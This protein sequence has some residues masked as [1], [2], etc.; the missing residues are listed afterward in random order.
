M[1]KTGPIGFKMSIQRHL[2]KDGSDFVYCTT[3]NTNLNHVLSFCPAATPVGGSRWTGR[4]KHPS[5][6]KEFLTQIGIGKL[7]WRIW[8]YYIPNMEPFLQ[9][10][11]IAPSPVTQALS[12]EDSDDS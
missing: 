11:E 9:L 8:Y 7:R 5:A 10:H 2:P 12:D 3:S 4:Q 6:L 1:R